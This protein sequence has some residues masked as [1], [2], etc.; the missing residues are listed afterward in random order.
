MTTTLWFNA[1]AAT[2]P[3]KMHQLNQD[4]TLIMSRSAEDGKAAGLYVVADGMGGHQAGEVASELAVN[5]MEQ[6][7][8]WLLRSP[9]AEDTQPSLPV[10]DAEFPR[11]PGRQAEEWVRRAIERANQV[12]YDYGDDNPVEAGNLGTTLTC[13]LL[14]G[15][16]AIVGNVGDSRTYLLRNSTL[17]QITQDHSYVAQLVREGQIEPE[18]VYTHP[19]RNVITRSLGHQPEVEIDS[20]VQEIEAGDRLLLCSDGLW[21][22]VQNQETLSTYLRDSDDPEAT[23]QALIAA[24]NAQ[25]GRDNIGVVVVHVEAAATPPEPP[26]A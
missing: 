21:E 11:D 4:D 7:L 19:R 23:V 14:L 20:W 26:S 2:D 17:K 8:G 22:M 18:A 10:I 15:N 24:A 16:L 5:T 9:A 3:G 13:A 25:G 1:A 6:E 12:I